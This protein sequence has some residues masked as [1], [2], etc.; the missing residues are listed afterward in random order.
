M[1]ALSKLVKNGRKRQVIRMLLFAGDGGSS[2][3]GAASGGDWGQVRTRADLAA[4]I[5]EASN[6]NE[7]PVDMGSNLMETG[8]EDGDV[9]YV[10]T[11]E[12]LLDGETGD[13]EDMDDDRAEALMDE[14]EE[15]SVVDTEEGEEEEGEEA[16]GDAQQD[17]GGEDAGQ[18]TVRQN[19]DAAAQDAGAAAVFGEAAATAGGTGGED[20]E[21]GTED[22]PDPEVNSDSDAPVDVVEPEPIR[23]KHPDSMYKPVQSI[24]S[25]SQDPLKLNMRMKYDRSEGGGLLVQGDERM[26]RNSNL[27]SMELNPHKNGPFGAP[28]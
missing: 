11:M 9:V 13:M 24:R 1:L 4:L 26:L 5:N 18:Q 27:C 23:V 21:E 28:M 14:E 8:E 22:I 3:T 7:E 6:I 25:G 2:D 15:V 20:G 19:P 12:G 17:G 16:L 10:R